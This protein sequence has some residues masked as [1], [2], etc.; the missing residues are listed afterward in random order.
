[1][2]EDRCMHAS[3][4]NNKTNQVA[5][6]T[7]MP[8]HLQQLGLLAEDNDFHHAIREQRNHNKIEPSEKQHKANIII[9]KKQTHAKL[10]NY[11]HAACY[12][13]V[14]STLVAATN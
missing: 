10:V 1:M 2:D 3:S 8:D 9:Q 5:I 4:V 7:T 11:L 6:T 12:L 14:K 13:P